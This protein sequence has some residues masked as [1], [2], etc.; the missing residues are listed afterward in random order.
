MHKAAWKGRVAWNA[1]GCAQASLIGPR[2]EG[3][4]YLY[5]LFKG[6]IYAEQGKDGCLHPRWCQWLPV[7]LLAGGGE[8]LLGSFGG[9]PSIASPPVPIPLL[10]KC[11]PAS[12]SPEP[13]KVLG[14]IGPEPAFFSLVPPSSHATLRHFFQKRAKCPRE[15]AL[16]PWTTYS[17]PKTGTCGLVGEHLGDVIWQP[18]Y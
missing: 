16:Q 10:G 18:E 5:I 1:L 3:G 7:P 12:H 11:S 14:H 17:K 9:P 13:K 2:G 6:V 15:T 4:A 8:S